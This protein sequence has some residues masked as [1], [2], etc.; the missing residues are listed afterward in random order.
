MALPKKLKNFNLFGNGESWQGQIDELTLPELA[1][2][3]EEFQGAGMDGTVEIDMGQEAITFEWTPAGLI[4]SIFDGFGHT[5]L[6]SQLLRFAGAYVRDDTDE[7]VSVE[8]VV[9]GR[10]KQ[11][12]MGTAKAGDNNTQTVTTSCSYYKLVINGRDVIEIDVPGFVFIVNGKDRLAAKR[13]AMG[14]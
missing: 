13:Q 14:L 11:I 2:K 7:T 9:R 6:D 5:E 1:R 4:E 12:G 8:I 3:V 10:H